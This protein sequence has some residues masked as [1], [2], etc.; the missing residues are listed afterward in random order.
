VSIN[1]LYR[2]VRALEE[3][4]G[5]CY[6]AYNRLQPKVTSYA[7]KSLKILRK[8]ELKQRSNYSAVKVMFTNL[9]S[10]FNEWFQKL[11]EA[12]E[13]LEEVIIRLGQE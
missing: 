13:G 12:S 10:E 4:V 2:Y 7:G 8:K 5:E 6:T 3:T 1:G 11:E 9:K